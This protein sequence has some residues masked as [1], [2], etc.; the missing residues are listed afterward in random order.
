MQLRDMDRRP[1]SAA[2]PP[3]YGHGVR[4][5]PETRRQT[6]NGETGSYDLGGGVAV[7]SALD[8]RE[9][10]QAGGVVGSFNASADYSPN[11]DPG[12]DSDSDPDPDSDSRTTL[13]PP[14]SSNPSLGEQ[15]V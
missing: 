10:G 7:S 2:S 6:A 15:A 14:Y 12:S 1:H 11:F 5:V 4:I 8:S 3:T 9:A 13:P